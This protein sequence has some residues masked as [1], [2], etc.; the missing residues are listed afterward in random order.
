MVKL[1]SK[2]YN[3]W[4]RFGTFLTR[5][6]GFGYFCSKVAVFGDSFWLVLKFD[7]VKTH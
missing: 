6:G 3:F 1:Y 7:I 4:E 2:K 5:R